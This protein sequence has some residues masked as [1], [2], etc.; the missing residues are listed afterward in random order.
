LVF[1][2]EL[3]G[4]PNKEILTEIDS[5]MAPTL[6]AAIKTNHKK[7]LEELFA[8]IPVEALD[9][10]KKLLVMNPKKRLSAKQAL[11]HPYILQLVISDPVIFL[12]IF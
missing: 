12:L 6:M 11:R 5:P 3:L 2:A 4:R 7:K 8:G 9:L 1:F 10:L